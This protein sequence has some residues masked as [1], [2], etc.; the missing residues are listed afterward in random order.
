MKPVKQ[1]VMAP[2]IVLLQHYPELRGNVGEGGWVTLHTQSFNGQRS[3]IAALN[4]LHRLGFNFDIQTN[5]QKILEDV[6]INDAHI[7]IDTMLTATWTL[8]LLMVSLAGV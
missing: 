1:K 7:K 6:S 5:D 3:S 4:Y 2:E 8:Y